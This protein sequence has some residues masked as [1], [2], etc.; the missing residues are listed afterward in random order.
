MRLSL[1]LLATALLLPLAAADQN[2]AAGPAS[3]KTQNTQWGNG[4]ESGDTGGEWRDAHANVA[5]TEHESVFVD[6]ASS[7]NAWSWND[8]MGNYENQT[9]HNFGV[10]A[11]RQTD[12]S[13]GPYVQYYA[14][15]QRDENSWSTWHACGSQLYASGLALLLGCMPN[16]MAPPTLPELP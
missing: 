6:A 14:W 2:L 9:W 15:D 1:V 8:G 10:A 13:W 7:C 11:G 12:S 16:G 3:V 5:A 4:C